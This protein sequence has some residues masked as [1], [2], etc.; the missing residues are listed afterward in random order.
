MTYDEGRIGLPTARLPFLSDLLY[1]T[2]WL[3]RFV[4]EKEAREVELIFYELYVGYQ[5]AVSG[6]ICVW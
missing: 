4:K 1:N 3:V 6:V 5:N 2:S